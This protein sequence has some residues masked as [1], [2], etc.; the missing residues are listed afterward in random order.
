MAVGMTLGRSGCGSATET[1]TATV[2]QPQAAPSPATQSQSTATASYIMPVDP[3]GSGCSVQLSQHTAIVIWTSPSLQ[4]QPACSSWIHV[5]AETGLL[6]AETSLPAGGPPAMGDSQ[7]CQLT[8][9]DKRATAF[10]WDSGSAMYGQAACTSL[11]AAGW[12]EV[13]FPDSAES[14]SG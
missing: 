14:T 10:V 1:V 4:V 7:V 8:S 3:G 9:D 2:S 11:I 6:W 13:P 12:S 5:Q